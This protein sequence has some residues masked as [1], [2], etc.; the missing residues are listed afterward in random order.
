MKA[1]LGLAR[2]TDEGAAG[3]VPF[4]RTCPGR[5]PAGR[6]FFPSRGGDRGHQSF[7]LLHT[8]WLL[9]RKIVPDTDWKYLPT[10][11]GNW[12]VAGPHAHF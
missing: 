10:A 5:C 7:L 4:A 11:G 6:T 2:V 1:P 3:A 12:G 8:Y 9:F